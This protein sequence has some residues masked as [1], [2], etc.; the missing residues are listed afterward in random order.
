LAAPSTHASPY[1]FYELHRNHLRLFYESGAEICLS[2]EATP[3]GESSMNSFRTRRPLLVNATQ[4]LH[5][6]LILTDAGQRRAYPG[7]WIIEG[8]NRER[9]IADNTFFQRTFAPIPGKQTVKAGTTAAKRSL[10]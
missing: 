1:K 8:E 2:A 9:Y 6:T 7:D 3:T 10:L 5:H 4:C